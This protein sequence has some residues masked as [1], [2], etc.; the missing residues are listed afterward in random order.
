[1]RWVTGS[2]CWRCRSRRAARP[3]CSTRRGGRR[4]AEAA[5]GGPFC[6]GPPTDFDLA[7]TRG[8][9]RAGSVVGHEHPFGDST[10]LAAARDALDQYATQLP[11]GRRVRLVEFPRLDATAAPCAGGCCA[12][13]LSAPNPNFEVRHRAARVR[14]ESVAARMPTGNQRPTAAALDGLHS[15]IFNQTRAMSSVRPADHQPAARLRRES[16]TPVC[17]DAQATRQNVIGRW[18]ARRQDVRGRARPARSRD[19]CSA[20]RISRLRAAPPH[21]RRTFTP[22]RTRPT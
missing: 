13:A 3:S 16:R 6:S 21:S 20:C 18:P 7:V 5:D 10:P 8:H 22:R 17:G 11:E 19:R 2:S 9:G 14:S 1:M 12:G 4:R 15:L